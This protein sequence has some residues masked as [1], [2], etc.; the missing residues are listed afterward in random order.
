M[1]LEKVFEPIVIRGLVIPNRIVAAAHG[2]NLS[3]PP[4]IVGGEDFV[5]YHVRRAKGGL[6]LSIL[7][8]MGVHSS[9]QA[10]TL[11]QDAAIERYR[12]IMRALRPYG[13]RVFQQ[14]F[15]IGSLQAVTAGG[16]IPWSVST[17]T[18][19]AGVIGDP[20]T[21]ERIGEV[22]SAFG[23]AARRCRD[24]GLDG[25]E[26]HA[27][28]GTL[29]LSFLSPIYNTR[30][31]EYGGSLEN[32][33]RF[34]QE[35]LRAIR[36][37]AGID[38]VVGIRTGASEM[39]GSIQEAELQVVIEALQ[40]E[41][42]IDYLMTT[43]GDFYRPVMITAGMEAPTGYQL[44]ST[45]QL[46]AVA[47]VPSIVAGR[48][49][50]LEEAER[51]IA[52]GVA[53]MVSMVRAHIADPD[54]VRKTREG[55]AH[56]IR[57]CI[58]CNQGCQGNARLTGGRMSCTVNPVVGFERTL[59]EDLIVPV[60]RPREVLVIGGGPAG[61]E[62][63]RVA[64]LCGHEVTLAEAASA[65]GGAVNAARRAPRSALIGDIVDWLGAAVEH[66][67]VDVLLDRY[68]SV[69]DV[70]RAA[71]D[72]VIVA[73]GST[74]R[75]DGFQPARPFEPARGVDLPH[76][77]SSLQL[78][79][80][81]PPSTAQSA[82]VLDT[83]GHFEAI[84][85][86]ESLVANGLAVTFVTSLPSFGAAPVHATFR[87]APALQFLYEGSF[88]LLTR[89]HLSEIRS[90]MC[91]VHPIHNEG[92]LREVPADV[93]VL[94]TQ[95][96]PNRQ[97][98]DALVAAGHTDVHIIGDAASPRTLDNA[99]AEGHRTAR[100]IAAGNPATTQYLRERTP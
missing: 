89:H 2:T 4:R 10:M 11:S 88:T 7:E 8:A 31:D 38:F 58:A 85:C 47:S 37:S 100:A 17:V 87:D 6:G 61:L 15:H 57:P 54:V 27:G 94:V 60:D 28:H 96:Q 29:P 22:V 19:L 63:A 18:S 70:E 84:S 55:R 95:N 66:G 78:L 32:R 69:A 42:L 36:A 41:G 67:G 93:V 25:V 77:L 73:T 64:A 24:G 68:M 34:I 91:L 92:R 12:E 5:A 14:L 45:S 35:V 1:G 83:V 50:T 81:G 49:R 33:M 40:R 44:P 53:D 16:G 80:S 71:P 62:A 97:I 39:P 99:I 21:T 74:P 23:A 79:T 72:V 20:L 75:L 98:Y 30:E 82:L 76:V 52:D 56:E 46:T 65:L 90:S 13:T 9:A 43:F 48:F 59:S 26:L 51:V 3:S 86:A